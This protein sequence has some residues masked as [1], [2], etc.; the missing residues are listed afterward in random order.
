[1]TREYNTTVTGE[2]HETGRGAKEKIK[3]QA[4]DVKHESKRQGRKLIDRGKSTAANVI[5]DFAD[6]LD[7]AAGELDERQRS[8]SAGYVRGAS[9]TMHRFSQ[10]LNDQS[11]DRS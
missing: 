6:A 10:T 7:S 4:E 5:T 8:A 11:A 1:M 9:E 3:E 2:S